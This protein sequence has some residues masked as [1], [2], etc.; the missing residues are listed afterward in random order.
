MEKRRFFK[1]KDEKFPYMMLSRLIM[2]RGYE[3]GIAD[4]KTK[5]LEIVNNEN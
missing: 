4:T 1:N 2:A 3:Q 5:I